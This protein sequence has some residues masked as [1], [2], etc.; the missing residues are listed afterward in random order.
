MKASAAANG[1]ATAAGTGTANRIGFGI[2]TGIA[3]GLI[4][5]A[6]AAEAAAGE[7]TIAPE[8]S[9]VTMVTTKQG[10]EFRGVFGEFAATIDFDPAHAEA[11]HITGVVKTGSVETHDE[12]NNTYV[13]SYLDVEKFPEARFESK[14]IEVFPGEGFRAT[15]DLTI[16]GVTNQ[17]ALDFTF[18]PDA[19]SGPAPAHAKL[20]G[21]IWVNRFDY[22][23]AN[24]VDTSWTARDVKVEVELDL[25]R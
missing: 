25:G 6:F 2:G 21:V 19:A 5:S 20:A 15:G 18:V 17:A 22:G 10:G 24:D 3:A 1:T 11:G 23:I 7:W 9:T 13:R 16:K 4:A 12:Q 14:K 8:T